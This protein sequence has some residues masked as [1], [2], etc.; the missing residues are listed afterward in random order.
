MAKA[1]V[2]DKKV[3]AAKQVA[4]FLATEVGQGKIFDKATLRKIVPNI[5]QVDRRMRDLRKVGWVIRN[6]KDMASL[7]PNELLLEKIG[8]ELWRENWKWPVQGLNASLRRKVFDR[9]G[10][11]CM[12][13]GIDFG[14]EF[15]DRPGVRARPTI[16]HVL[17]LERGGNSE[18]ENLRPECQFCNEQ[19]KNTTPTP[20]DTDLLKRLIGELGRADKRSLAEWM[21]SGRRTFTPAEKLWMQYRQLPG[22]KRVEIQE[23][24]INSL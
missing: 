11:R 22:P 19:G 21:N 8:E 17:P 15:P 2:K 23:A 20:I 12:V 5:E 9:D 24:L 6:Y 13:C 10:P 1:H 14:A 18:L 3:G 7:K 16:G 4:H